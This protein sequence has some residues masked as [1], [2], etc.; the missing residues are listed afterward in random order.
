[1]IMK[2]VF[3]GKS[4]KKTRVTRYMFKAL[5]R[6][7]QKVNF[8]NLPRTRKRYFWTDYRKIIYK[9]I[10][11]A[12]PDLVLIF[13]T[14][15]PYSV[16]QKI[17]ND[18]ITAIF[19]PDHDA[20]RS[21][22][23]VRCGR[24][25]DYVF[26]NNKSQH[27]ELKSLGV[28]NPA[29]SMEACDPDENRPIP[30]RRRKWASDVA[31]IGKPVQ[32]NRIELMRAVDQRFNLKIWGGRWEEIGLTSHTKSIYPRQYGKI[33]YASKIMLGCDQ[34]HE[35]DSYFSNRTWFTMGFGGFLLTNYVPGLE[36]I[37]TRGK[38]LEWYH[39]IEECLD[40]IDYYLQH[41]AERRDIARAGCEYVHAHHTWD[42][43]ID[44]IISRIEHDRKTA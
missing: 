41:E 39:S 23:L 30:T 6:R 7:V 12:D 28:K 2:V 16:L 8:I 18:Y 1:M 32:K 35:M 29:F 11:R 9:K 44:K 13:S 10:R 40:L 14:D 36:K 27:A 3:L 17:K 22:R 43:V 25:T 21:E 20:P 34:S 33:C 26:L 31:F 37:L 38:H 4:K 19:F 42:N 15:I 24:I 5:Q